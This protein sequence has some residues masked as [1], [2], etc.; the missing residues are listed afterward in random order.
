[1]LT[2]KTVDLSNRKDVHRFIEFPF[3]IYRNDPNW[4]PPLWMDM[5]F[6]LNR[7]KNPF[8]EHSEADFFLAYQGD[9]VVGR[10]AAIQNR[11]F[12]AYHHTKNA[13]FYYFDC[14]DD[15]EVASALF[16]RVFDWARERSLDTLI[17]PK[18]FGVL[19]GYGMLVSGF[20]QPSMMTM[21][22]HNPPYYLPF[23]ERLGFVKEV[24]FISTRIE[25]ADFHLPERIHRIA[26]WAEKRGGIK[27]H[28]FNS[29]KELRAWSQKIGEAYNKAFVNNWE[30]APM[31]EREIR[32]VVDTLEMI[33]DPKLIKIMSHGEDVIGFALAFP[34][35]SRAIQ[36]SRGRLFPFGLIDILLEKRRTRWVAAN[37][38]GILP[39]FQGMGGNALLYV[40][41]ERMFRTGQFTHA[42]LY[43]VA[44]TAV[45]MRRDL[46]NVGAIPFKNH[47]VYRRS[48]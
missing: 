10:V 18:G 9:Q 6:Q 46:E 40:E 39:E 26:A 29:I 17:G 23:M 12:N 1:M 37:G 42:A 3:K 19:D 36:R 32:M 33:A 41:G 21:M 14:I 45:Q 38:G 11:R 15:F 44:E 35:L 8:F 13:Q 47:R 22:N 48:I 25:M 5:K 27:V 7:V 43:Q 20:D 28:N 24:D 34:D 16:E 30:Y 4:V 2:I 31:T